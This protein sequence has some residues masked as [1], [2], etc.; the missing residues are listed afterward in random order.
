VNQKNGHSH[1]H[2]DREEEALVAGLLTGD[3]P[4]VR[5]FLNR[6]HEQVYTLTARLT[7]DQELRHDWCQDILLQIVKE[8]GSGRFVYT[9]PGCFWAW[10]K[11]R[12]HFLLINLYHKEKKHTERWSTGEVGEALAENMPLE[13]GTDP[14]RVLEA[15]EARRI[16]EECLDELGSEDQRRALSLVLFQDQ[17]YQEVSEFTGSAL[18]TVRSWI[19]RARI[20]MRQCVAGKFGHETQL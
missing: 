7:H 2:R 15:V 14:L 16:I 11:S 3:S 19:R 20:A 8:M 4:S 12:A 10:F 17:S 18:N 9:R 1:E 13:K 5:E 6:S